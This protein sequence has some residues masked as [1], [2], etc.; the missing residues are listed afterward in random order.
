MVA[1]VPTIAFPWKY[2]KIVPVEL[3]VKPITQNCDTA[4]VTKLAPTKIIKL[5]W[6][7]CVFYLYSSEIFCLN[8]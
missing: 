5:V 8:S 7:K 4:I 2:F 3:V 6:L 1:I